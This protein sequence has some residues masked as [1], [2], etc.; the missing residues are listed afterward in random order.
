M[1]YHSKML[2]PC[3]IPLFTHM[4]LDTYDFLMIFYRMHKYK[5]LMA[6]KGSFNPHH[7]KR[8]MFHSY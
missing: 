4:D 3:K 1:F 6:N 7:K 8:K 5:N 2:R